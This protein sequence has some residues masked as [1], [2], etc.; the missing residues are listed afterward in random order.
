MAGQSWPGRGLLAALW[1]AVACLAALPGARRADAHSLFVL[2]QLDTAPPAVAYNQPSL[3]G[4]TFINRWS[5]LE[6]RRGEFNW[7]ALDAGVAQAVAA[8]RQVAL[9]VTPGVFT[10]QWVLDDAQSLGATWNLPWGFSMCEDVRFPLP[11]D[12]NY[13]AAWTEFVAALGEHYADNPNVTIVKITGINVQTSEF[14]L[15]YAPPNL[16]A[17]D[18]QPCGAAG[19]LSVADWAAAGY[20]PSKVMSA[21]GAIARAFGAAFPGQLLVLQT[22]GWGF[23]P[24]GDDG[25]PKSGATGDFGLAT[26]IYGSGIA[27]LGERFGL[28]NNGLSAGY[29]WDRPPSVP[30][31]TPLGYQAAATITGDPTCRMNKFVTPCDEVA[32]ANAVVGRALAHG[33]IFMEIYLADLTNRL[34]APSWAAYKD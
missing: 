27:I 21:F 33:V 5:T 25:V 30:A 29:N 4:V 26:R 13:L 10:P 31:T 7:A 34:L 6:P 3:R 12:P 11:W 9:S 2:P 15:P 19:S 8:G 17:A 23:P 22:G 18:A 14:L 20:A 32:V 1:L 16:P 24:I 28:A